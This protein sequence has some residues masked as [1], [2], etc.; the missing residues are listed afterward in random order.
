MIISLIVAAAENNV[1]G[2]DGQL[3][4]HL[5]ADMKYFK[6]TTAGHT[7][8]MGRGTFESLGKPLPGRTNI[9]ITRQQQYKAQGCTIVSNIADAISYAKEN[10]T[11]E[12]F[13]IGGGEVFRQSMSLADRIYLTRIFHSFDGDTF[14]P[15][16][17]TDDWKMVSEERHQPDE[18]NKYA[19]AFQ[20][21]EKAN[22]PGN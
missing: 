20:V 15:E 12:T 21:F 22:D 3:P 9:V 17:N 14:F 5:P 13:I 19:F 8:I 4:W 1:I 7:V 11:A 10:G 18:R 16:L 2:K 6:Q